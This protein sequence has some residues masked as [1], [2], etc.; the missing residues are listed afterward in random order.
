MLHKANKAG[1]PYCY[2]QRA[3]ALRAESTV[4]LSRSSGSLSRPVQAQAECTCRTQ[5]PFPSW[6]LAGTLSAPTC[7]LEL[8]AGV[9]GGSCGQQGLS[10]L[11]EGSVPSKGPV[12]RA[13]PVCSLHL[14]Q[15][16]DTDQG[17][18]HAVGCTGSVHTRERFTRLPL[19][20]WRGTLPSTEH[21]ASCPPTLQAPALA[22][23]PL[24]RP[25]P[26]EPGLPCCPAQKEPRV[27][28]LSQTLQL[29][30]P[31]VQHNAGQGAKI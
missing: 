15:L 3:W 30:S 22:R 5:V 16:K 27:T 9:S 18:G 4:G 14:N 2:Q 31:C 24:L 28:P 1:T 6:L 23:C 19:R 29:G 11:L 13:G 21:M 26:L 20:G 25:L 17:P 10:D 12:T 7:C 8:F